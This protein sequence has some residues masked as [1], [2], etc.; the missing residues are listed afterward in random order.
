MHSTQRFY[1][2]DLWLMN[3]VSQKENHSLIWEYDLALNMENLN[4]K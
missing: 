3:Y 1:R 2:L 4:R